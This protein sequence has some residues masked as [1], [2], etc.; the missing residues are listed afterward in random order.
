MVWG[1]AGGSGL[2]VA[3]GSGL[4]VGFINGKVHEVTICM[5]IH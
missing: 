5:C 2:D 1:V 3:K 4:G